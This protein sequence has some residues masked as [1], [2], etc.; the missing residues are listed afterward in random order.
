MA[1]ITKEDLTNKRKSVLLFVDFDSAN[2]ESVTLKREVEQ[3]VEGDAPLRGYIEAIAKT[4]PTSDNPALVLAL[5][6]F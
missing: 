1:A 6:F 2:P 5:P 3:I 4:I